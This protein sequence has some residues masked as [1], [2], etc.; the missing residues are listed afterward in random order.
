M[1][2]KMFQKDKIHIG[3]YLGHFILHHFICKIYLDYLIFLDCAPPPPRSEVCGKLVTFYNFYKFLV[4]SLMN[5]LQ[6]SNI[7]YQALIILNI[8]LYRLKI[9]EFN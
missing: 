9:S 1:K 2:K 4:C 3:N 6:P 5:G 7:I 8:C